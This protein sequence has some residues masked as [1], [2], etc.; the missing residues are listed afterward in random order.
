MSLLPFGRTFGETFDKT[1]RCDMNTTVLILPG[2]DG[3]D[4]MLG[5]FCERFARSRCVVAK[6]LPSDPEADYAALANHFS[7]FVQNLASC[8]IIA[9]SFSGPIGVLLAHRYPQV[10]TRLTLVASFVTSPV[11]KTA[12]ILPWSAMFRLPL[13]SLVAGHFF[14]GGCKSLVPTLRSAIRQ[15]TPAV[16]RHRFRLVQ[17]VDVSS[18]YSNLKCRLEYLRPTKDRLVPRRCVDQMVVLNPDTTILNIDGPHLILETQPEKASQII[19][20]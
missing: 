17:N 10:V 9:Q 3:T 8:H 1:I 2:L 5:E 19:G 15:N 14:V 11:P 6:T 7:D 16:L 18:E 20:R 13:P 12:A 4:L